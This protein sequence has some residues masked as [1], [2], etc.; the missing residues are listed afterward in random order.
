M[1]PV[2]FDLDM[3]LINSR[4]A[5]LAS[6]AGVA[7]DAATDIDLEAVDRRL[8]IKL[9]DELA[10]WFPP[11]QIAA[12]AETYRRHYLALAEQLTT[13]LPGAHEALGAGRAG[14]QAVARRAA[15]P[16]PRPPGAPGRPKP[17]GGTTWRWP[18]SSPPCCPART[19]RWPRSGRRA[20]AW[21]SSRPSTP[22][23]WSQIGRAARRE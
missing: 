7:R 18:S 17:T 9:D 10:F 23:R 13:V 4:P 12:A 5:I 14:G 19:R 1:G 8:G 3:T 20:S 16:P 22:S 6:F 21:G 15:R 11:G 2:G